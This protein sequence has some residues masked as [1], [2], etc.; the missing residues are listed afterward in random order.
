MTFK[1]VK[2][3][4]FCKMTKLYLDSE[5]IEPAELRLNPLTLVLKMLQR[6]FGSPAEGK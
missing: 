4:N 3:F 2:Y 1:K 6:M 5:Y